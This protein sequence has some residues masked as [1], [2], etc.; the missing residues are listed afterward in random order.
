[1][2]QYLGSRGAQQG[3][4]SCPY[5]SLCVSILGLAR[6]PTFPAC[7]TVRPDRVSILGLARSPTTRM[8]ASSI[9]VL[10]QYLGSRGAQ[11]HAVSSAGLA[12][13]VSIL[14]LARSPTR[15]FQ[16]RAGTPFRFNTWAREEPNDNPP[17]KRALAVQFQYLGSRGA[18]LCRMSQV[19]CFTVSILGLAR[20]PTNI[21]S[22]RYF[23]CGV[24]ILGLARSP[25]KRSFED[26]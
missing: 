19:A 11:R 2:F 21:G 17:I 20:S 24:S 1:M 9:Q 5:L 10:F 15:L 18:Q 12:V 8:G 3:F 25:T 13:S 23:G 14:G 26:V 4:S 6:S 7:K 16:C 22:F